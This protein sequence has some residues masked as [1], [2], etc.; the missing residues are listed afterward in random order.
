VC[1]ERWH[2]ITG[3]FRMRKGLGVSADLF[4][5]PTWCRLAPTNFPA[6]VQRASPKFPENILFT[7]RDAVPSPASVSGSVAVPAKTP[8][9]APSAASAAPVLARLN[10]TL[11]NIGSV[12]AARRF[13]PRD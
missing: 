6:L 7:F 11:L 13:F 12:K 1:D 8:S 3:K 9:L 5:Q 10:Q 2:N 4:K